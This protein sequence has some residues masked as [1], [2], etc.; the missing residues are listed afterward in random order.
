MKNITRDELKSL[1]KSLYFELEEKQI[2]ELQ[3]EFTSLFES[4][5]N[6]SKL[7][8]DNL[9]PTN[10]ETINK[11]NVLRDDVPTSS[12]SDAIIKNASNK[13]GRYI[14]IK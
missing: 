11:E 10:W 7:N 14:E 4:F 2:D 1:A 13:K 8:V 3:Q 5:E 12:N 9:F 6:V